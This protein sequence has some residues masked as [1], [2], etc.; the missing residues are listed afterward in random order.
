MGPLKNFKSAKG[1][2]ECI[3]LNKLIEDKN[4]KLVISSFELE[5][6]QKENYFH[7]SLLE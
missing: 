6:R 7:F 2:Q 4:I 5:I 3:I 1:K